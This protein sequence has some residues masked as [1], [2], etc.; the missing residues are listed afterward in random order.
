VQYLGEKAERIGVDPDRLILKTKT[1]VH[2]L[3]TFFQHDLGP[4]SPRNA[5][6]EDYC[7]AWFI[8]CASITEPYDLDDWQKCLIK[9]LKDASTTYD[10]L[11]KCTLAIQRDSDSDVLREE[12]LFRINRHFQP[13]WFDDIIR[14]AAGD[15]G[16]DGIN[17]SDLRKRNLDYWR[18]SLEGFPDGVDFRLEARKLIEF[19]L[20]E[21]FQ[22]RLPITGKDIMN[23]FELSPGP[24]IGKLLNIAK[25]IYDRDPC[26][27]EILLS[28]LKKHIS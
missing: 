3:R 10:V 8:S 6:L 7:R 21:N 19:K 22:E 12:W 9:L 16:Q 24:N 5:R 14:E 23:I 18:K 17:I 15:I 2:H 11:V 28:Q 13:S 26:N 4:D 1:L 27:K 25:E 20:L